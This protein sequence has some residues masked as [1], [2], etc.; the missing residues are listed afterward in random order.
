MNNILGNTFKDKRKELGMTQEELA[1]KL[2]ITF[3]AVS[4]WE[5]GISMPDIN[6]LQSISQLFNISIDELITGKSDQN[7]KKERAKW[8][9]IIGTVTND[10]HA[11]IGK[12]IGDVKGD[13][14]GDVNGNIQG[15]TQNI[16][17]NVIGNILGTVNG[18]ITG[19]VSG[20]LY[21]VVTGK[22]K[23]GVRGKVLGSIIGDG[24]NV[25]EENNKKK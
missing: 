15:E 1:E 8:G 12:I 2:G 16:Y 10:I 22:V 19:Y 11:D 23:L 4:K 14:Y 5:T 20:N 18:D 13:I 9:K 3:Q 7:S 21:G 17:G 25:P 24:I 6:M